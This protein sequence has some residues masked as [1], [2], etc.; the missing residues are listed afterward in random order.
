M[1]TP[2]TT[3][4]DGCA[5]DGGPA[6]YECAVGRIRELEAELARVREERDALLATVRRLVNLLHEA[7]A[8]LEKRPMS[9]CV[10]SPDRLRDSIASE[11]AAIYARSASRSSGSGS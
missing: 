4:W 6:H 7:K 1:T 2:Q 8:H 9:M 11:L 5:T 3:H 10:M